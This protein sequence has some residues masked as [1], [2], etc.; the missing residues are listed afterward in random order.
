MR[1]LIDRGL[2]MAFRLM[3]L[4]SHY[5]APLTFSDEGL[6]A[7]D[8]GLDRLRAAANPDQ[9]RSADTP[10]GESANL[11]SLSAESRERFETAMDDDFDTP[12]AVAALFD[13]A[14]AINRSH[15]AGDDV[16]A[17]D[18]ARQTLIELAGVLGLDLT[19]PVGRRTGDAVPFIDLLVRVRDELRAAKQWTLADLIR[20]ELTGHGV[21]IA[22]G[23][24]G[25]TWRST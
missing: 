24:N 4:Q 10:G 20:D 9:P 19:M 5:R 8:R 7:A 14:R 1:D 15:A 3:V 17:V 21:A 12:R 16:A 2:A 22:D 11:R 23:P 18:V 25:S 13:L 6:E